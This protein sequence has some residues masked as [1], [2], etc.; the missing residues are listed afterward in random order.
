MKN[1][2]PRFHLY[3]L[4]AF[5][6]LLLMVGC[7]KQ[8]TIELLNSNPQAQ[9]FDGV[10]GEG[11]IG[12]GP[13]SCSGVQS[14]FGTDLDLAHFENQPYADQ[15]SLVATVTGENECSLEGCEGS[16]CTMNSIYRLIVI[17]SN[18]NAV[19]FNDFPTIQVTNL[20]GGSIAYEQSGSFIKA[21]DP[22]RV[23]FIWPT[24]STLND[25]FSSIQL[26]PG[27]LCI[28]D[29][30]TDPRGQGGDPTPVGTNE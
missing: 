13:C 4:L 7:S 19:D 22:F 24:S 25:A 14:T 18:D 6:M 16:A 17:P 23:T 12:I 15:S 3:S 9:M 1:L 2:K 26:Q 8:E 30:M 28:I 29:V 10:P 21:N 5:S 27:G 11:G 20:N